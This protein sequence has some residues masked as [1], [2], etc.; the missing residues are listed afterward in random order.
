MVFLHSARMRIV[1]VVSLIAPAWVSRRRASYIKKSIGI[2]M[3]L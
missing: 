3:P 2:P 1:T